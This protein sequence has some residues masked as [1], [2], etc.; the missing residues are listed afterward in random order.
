MQ[1]KSDLKIEIANNPETFQLA[2]KIKQDIS[3]AELGKIPSL[4]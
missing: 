4:E 2:K 1:E 3:T